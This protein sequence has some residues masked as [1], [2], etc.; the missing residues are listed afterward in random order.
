MSKFHSFLGDASLGS[1]S[2]FVRWRKNP[3]LLQIG[4]SNGQKDGGGFLKNIYLFIY[5][6]VP[7]LSCSM[8][9]LRSLLRFAGSLVEARGIQFLD[10][11]TLCLECRV[12]AIGPQ[13]SFQMWV[14]LKNPERFARMRLGLVSSGY[15]SVPS[16]LPIS[17]APTSEPPCPPHLLVYRSPQLFL[18]KRYSLMSTEHGPCP[19]ASLPS[20]GLVYRL[21]L[22]ESESQAY[23]VSPA[24]FPFCS[25]VSF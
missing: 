5:L 9:D 17:W 7:G 21:L 22:P 2:S 25:I 12:L 10:Q 8:Q 14:A 6:V 24:F 16:H 3:I 4:V 23:K 20:N 19:S 1:G 11:G 18:H 15:Q 13:R